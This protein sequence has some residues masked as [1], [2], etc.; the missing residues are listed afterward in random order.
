VLFVALAEL[1][2]GAEQ[3]SD[4]LFVLLLH[5]TPCRWVLDER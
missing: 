3:G 4:E 5:V 2:L 1:R